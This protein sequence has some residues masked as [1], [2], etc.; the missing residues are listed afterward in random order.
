MGAVVQLRPCICGK[1]GAPRTA[2]AEGSGLVANF[3]ACDECLDRSIAFLA[4][5]RPVFETMRAV[6]IPGEIANETMSFL[7]DQIPDDAML[8]KRS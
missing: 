6:G 4:K 7:L 2:T 5:V 8:E 1:P 3:I